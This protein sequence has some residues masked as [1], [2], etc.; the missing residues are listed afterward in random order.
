MKH[1][2]VS[3][4]GQYLS[5]R[6]ERLLIKHDSQDIAEFSL[7]KLHTITVAKQGVSVS[8]NLIQSCV[9]HGIRL[10]FLDNLG[11]CT[12]CVS[13]MQSNAIGRIRRNQ[14]VFLED[15]VETSSLASRIVFGKIRNQRAVLLYFGK[16]IKQSDSERWQVI[17]DAVR[18]LESLSNSVLEAG[19]AAEDVRKQLL[20][21]EGSSAN[22]YW[23]ALIDTKLLPNNFI[24]RVGRGANDITNMALNYGY[25]ILASRIWNAILVAGL[26]PYLGIYHVERPGK[27]SLVLDLMEEYRAWCVDRAIIKNRAILT[28]QQE[29][30]PAVKK[31]IIDEVL[32]VFTNHYQYKGTNLSLQSI[33]QRQMYRLSGH[34]SGNKV[35]KP[36]SFKW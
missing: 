21:L 24:T 11:N 8:S 19:K 5:Q 26:E 36:Y 10:F 25:A 6:G 29:L 9:L 3:E 34:F 18:S 28:D 15:A 12:A 31:V 13:G 32:R 30:T 1:L 14:V 27:P 20:G 22:I 4:Y 7:N 33:I 35:Y 23:K 17:S 16:Y 2:V